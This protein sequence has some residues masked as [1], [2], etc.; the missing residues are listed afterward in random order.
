M[1]WLSCTIFC[2]ESKCSFRVHKR[3]IFKTMATF[4]DCL[5]FL[6][7]CKWFCLY[8]IGSLWSSWP[9]G[10]NWFTWQACK[11]L[12]CTG[13]FL[14]WVPFL[15]GIEQR[16]VHRMCI[17]SCCLVSRNRNYSYNHR[18]FRW[19]WMMEIWI[20]CLVS[21]SIGLLILYIF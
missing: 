16:S 13:W 6:Y 15:S 10:W 21:L 4:Y 18:S 19:I 11:Y 7:M 14:M 9:E 1:E 12:L 8:F 5:N 3:V 20:Q 17:L 2:C